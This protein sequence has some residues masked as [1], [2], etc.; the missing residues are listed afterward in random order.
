M[1]LQVASDLAVFVA[2]AVGKKGRA[3]K[4]EEAGRFDGRSAQT[5]YHPGQGLLFVK[6]AVFV[7]GEITHA[8][9]LAAGIGGDFENVTLRQDAA[10]ATGFGACASKASWL[11]PRAPTGQPQDAQRSQ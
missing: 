5:K 10:M 8:R 9:G 2:E 7:A 11:V 3:G 1:E 6:L 4:Q